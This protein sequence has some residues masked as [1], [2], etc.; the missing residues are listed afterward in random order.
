MTTKPYSALDAQYYL[1]LMSGT[2]L[3]GLDIVLCNFDTDGRPHL[4]SSTTQP[5]PDTLKHDLWALTRPAAGELDNYG[6]LDR[7]FA[8]FCA[9]AINNFLAQHRLKATKIIAIGSH[10]QTVRHRPDNTPPF[11][12]QLGCAST[13]A[14]LTGIDVVAN[15]RQKDIALGGQ[16]APLA[17]AFHQAQFHQAGEVRSIVNIGGI[18][19]A[20][21]FDANGEMT[22]FDTGPGNG[23]MDSWFHAHNPEAKLA[24]DKNGQWASQG[25]VHPELLTRC[26]A[27]PYF[28]RQGPK[29]T[30]REYFQ[31]AWLENITAGLSADLTMRPVDV[32]RTLLELTARTI[33]EPLLQRHVQACYL[34]GGGVHNPLL[35]A[36]LQQ[37]LAPAQVHSSSQ[38]GIDPDAVEALAFAWFAWCFIE[39]KTVNL[40]HVTGAQREAILGALYP[41]R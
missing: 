9:Q 28:T 11:T 32:Q 13:I 23:L 19:N 24:Y 1:G 36:R 39:R 34:C 8:I 12:L 26:L 29:S 14:A 2:S 7:S 16:G 37:L 21:L 18:A 30:G 10:G 17:P 41:A 27:D 15:F 22:G 38:L 35:K 33:A 40:S 6:M 3:D 4:I 31:L 5:L 25:E 20:T